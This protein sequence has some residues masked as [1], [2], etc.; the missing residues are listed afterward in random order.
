[1]LQTLLEVQEQSLRYFSEEIHD[2]I[3][4][5]LSIAKLHL[6]KIAKNT[7]DTAIHTAAKQSTELLTKAISDLRTISHTANGGMVLNAELEESI[8]K[9]L[10]Y[11]TSAKNINCTFDTY[12]ERH[13][14]GQEK[15]LLLFR[16]VQESIANALKH[17]DPTS[18]HISIVYQ[19]GELVV[20][21]SDNG[22]GFDVAEKKKDA[23][24][25]LTNMNTR[26]ALLKGILAIDSVKGKG[27][28]IKLNIPYT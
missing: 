21:V 24:L 20:T 5:V 10:S 3:G 15:N 26:A 28:T 18:I 14:L 25:G 13:S 19:S 1:M 2:N 4:Q 22:G 16:I 11:I 17:G 6:Y 8:Q 7:T 27:T 23:G 9:E 12:G